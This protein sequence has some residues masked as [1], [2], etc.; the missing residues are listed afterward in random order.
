[1]ANLNSYGFVSLS[2]IASQRVAPNI[3][4]VDT[5]I[6]ESV[7]EHNRQ[8]AAVLAELV[9]PTTE[10]YLRYK[11]R[12]SGSLQPLDEWGNPKPVLAQ[13]QYD[14]AF[15]IKKAGHAWGDNRF[16]RAMMTVQDA[17]GY[18][19]DALLRDANWMKRHM[20]AAL[21]DN[22][23]Y[24]FLDENDKVGTLTIQPLANGDTAAYLKKN[25]ET[26]TDTHYYAQADAIDDTHNPF[27]ALETELSEHMDNDGPY[28][29]Y[30]PTALKTSIMALAT[31]HDV[32]DA[33]LRRGDGQTVLVGNIDRGFGD[34][35]LGYVEPGIWIVEWSMLP[36]THGIMVAR[37]ATTPALAMREYPVP[38]LQG[39]FTDNHSPDGNLNE[40]RFIRAA[41]FGALNRTAAL[42]F[43]IGN[44]T[45]QIPAGYATP[46]AA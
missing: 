31:F 38:E 23:S 13:G 34:R 2:D 45:Y 35:V 27:P 16:S 42:A 44:G 7:V 14:V 28:V 15:P 29:A 21:L 1:M 37:G 26:G 5:A 39:L 8:V 9:E 32:A 46:L 43:Q 25:G 10:P 33:N 6:R 11:V 4:V 17:D 12:G 36:S 19:F 3:R 30:I 41:G 22:T 20:L 40:Y 18:T 24:T